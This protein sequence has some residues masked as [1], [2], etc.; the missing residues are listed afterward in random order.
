M[1]EFL[2]SETE[3]AAE[4]I[5][6]VIAPQLD[7]VTKHDVAEA[8]ADKAE[9]IADAVATAEEITE[10]E[11]AAIMTVCAQSIY[12]NIMAT[13]ATAQSAFSIESLFSE[14]AVEEFYA[15]QDEYAGKFSKAKA[16]IKRNPTKYIGAGGAAAGG[17]T[18]ALLAKKRGTSVKKGAIVGAL[19]GGG[20][21][22]TGAEGNKL[23]KGYKA[24]KTADNKKREALKL[25]IGARKE[26]FKAPLKRKK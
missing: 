25:A 6:E 20:I 12:T 10:E 13:I 18:G 2:F 8:A 14:E 9:E 16:H 4:E 7:E 23:R 19:V 26:S 1:I 15:E 3:A 22:V 17:A 24:S 11:Y 21:G 5:T